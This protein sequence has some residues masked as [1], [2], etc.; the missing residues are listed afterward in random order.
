MKKRWFQV[1]YVYFSLRQEK[2]RTRQ[3]QYLFFKAISVKLELLISIVV[4]NFRFHNFNTTIDVKENQ[5]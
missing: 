1:I 2:S 5:G 3:R 4:N